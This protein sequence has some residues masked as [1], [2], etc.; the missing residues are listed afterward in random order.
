MNCTFTLQLFYY[1]MAGFQR[2]AFI[3][4]TGGESS[5][6]SWVTGSWRITAHKTTSEMF[7]ISNSF[8]FLKSV[9]LQSELPWEWGPCGNQTVCCTHTI[10]TPTEGNLECSLACLCVDLPWKVRHGF[11]HLQRDVGS[12]KVWSSWIMD[13]QSVPSLDW[14]EYLPRSE[15]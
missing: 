8:W 7:C 5:A 2:L 11:S 12:K 14:L 10:Y 4:L 15:V 13:V 6:L 1:L 9:C 3:R